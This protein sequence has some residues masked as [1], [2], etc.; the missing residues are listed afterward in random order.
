MRIAVDVMGG[1]HGC[2]VV[3]SGVKLALEADAR[4]TS[5]LLVGQ[6][7]ARG[8]THAVLHGDPHV[9][10]LHRARILRRLYDRARWI[11]G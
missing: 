1:D 4:I 7:E 3:I 11:S 6:E 2:G 8:K 5:V 10:F 9:T